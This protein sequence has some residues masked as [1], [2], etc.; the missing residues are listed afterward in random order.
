LKVFTANSLLS[1]ESIS[2]SN[3]ILN[4]NE[5]EDQNKQA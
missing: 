1:N 4:S 5:I 3:E 2:Y